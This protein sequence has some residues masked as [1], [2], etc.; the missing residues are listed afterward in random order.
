MRA[1]YVDRK[2]AALAAESGA[3]VVRV[4]G[5]RQVSLPLAAVERLVVRGSASLSTGLLAA[6]W[7]QDAGLLVLGGRRNEA[8]ARMLGRPHSDTGLRLAQYALQGDAATRAA[9]ARSL[10]TG[11]L[12]GQRRVV[13]R[14]LEA[15]GGHP[16]RL[17]RAVAGAQRNHAPR[18]GPAQPDLPRLL[19][20][21]GAAAAAYFEGSASLFAPALAFVGRNRRPPRDP[22]NA[23][24]SLGY[25][26]LQFE[27]ARQCQIVGL[28]PQLGLLHETAPGR[29]ALACDL[30]EPLRGHVDALVLAL[31]RGGDLRAEHFRSHAQA[32]LM[33]K[34]AR[35]R[36]YA[37]WEARGAPVGRLLRLVARETA[38]RIRAAVGSVP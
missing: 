16:P 24:L 38:R 36:L 31:F 2:H 28:D 26:L 27:A 18:E 25:T 3:L 9:L 33:G 23:A 1:V 30:V 5:E 12:A 17:P 19:G 37:A 7:R 8:T 29:D 11:K 15:G 6:L 35:E 22:V 34:T 4:A 20:L 13:R 32:R 14:P 21:E 10:V